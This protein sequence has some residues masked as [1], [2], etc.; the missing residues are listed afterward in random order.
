MEEVD[1]KRTP[2]PLSIA[3]T[4][5]NGLAKS[6]CNVILIR[7]TTRDKVAVACINEFIF[8]NK[9]HYLRMKEFPLDTK[10]MTPLKKISK[11]GE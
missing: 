2:N 6:T 7:I 10:S 9:F 3:D 11:L 4:I 5:P 1:E 8:W